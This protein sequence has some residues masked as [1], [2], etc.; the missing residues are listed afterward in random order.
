MLEGALRERVVSAPTLVGQLDRLL[1]VIGLPTLDLG[2][3]PFEAAVPVFPLS[4]FRLY[5]DLVIVESIV[6]EQQLAEADDVA[7]YE[8]YVAPDTSSRWPPRVG[9]RVSN[10][11][12]AASASPAKNKFTYRVHRQDRYSVSAPPSSSPTAAPAPAIAPNTPNALPRSFG[13]WT[14][15]VRIDSADGAMMAAKTPWQARTRAG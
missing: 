13:S 8:K 9:F 4:G 5:D 10:T 14:V 6:G 2:I 11:T 7:R 1:A 3:I 15:L 12:A